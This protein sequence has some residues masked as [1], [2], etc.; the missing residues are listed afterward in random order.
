MKIGALSCR[1]YIIFPKILR[2]F[3]KLFFYYKQLD[4]ISMYSQLQ[5]Y[6]WYLEAEK[7]NYVT[8]KSRDLY[9]VCPP[10]PGSGT[11]PLL[12]TV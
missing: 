10:P 2:V 5:E 9:R 11:L 1:E 8:Q 4:F 3:L 7:K 12:K 6:Q